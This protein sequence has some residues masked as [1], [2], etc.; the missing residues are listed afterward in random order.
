MLGWVQRPKAHDEHAFAAYVERQIPVVHELDETAG[1]QYRPRFR[2]KRKKT[3]R[4]Q[5][6]AFMEKHGTG[7]PIILITM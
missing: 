4:T 6:I 1:V 2:F 5:G 7:L 3:A